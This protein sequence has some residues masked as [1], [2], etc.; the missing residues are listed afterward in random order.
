M[1]SKTH[2]LHVGRLTKPAISLAFG[3]LLWFALFSQLSNAERLKELVIEGGGERIKLSGKIAFVAT[4]SG[5]KEIYVCNANGSG[6]RRVTNDKRLSVSPAI[7]A[8]GSRVVHTGYGSGY[9]DIYHIDLNSGRRGRIVKAPGTNSGANF[10]PDGRRIALT[11]SFVG[12]PEI[13]VTSIG[14]NDAKRLTNTPGVETSPTWAP[15][16]RNIAYS[17]DAGG[18]PQL[19]TISSSGGRP[20][21]ISTGHSHCTE[22]S[23]SPDGR[24]LA[25]NVRQGGSYGVAVYDFG[26]RK[27]RLVGRGEDPCW[28][29]DSRHLVFSTGRDLVIHDTAGGA[30]TRIVSGFGKISEPNWSRSTSGAR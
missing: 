21:H 8:D 23:W 14:G 7:S 20:R 18:R 24:K 4:K 11:M 17:S 5:Q 15:D 12:N 26:T 9:A 10:S 16:G 28:G 2:T 3:T 13:F 22:P 29:P 19:Y 6:V 27:T 25:F 1:I 30:T